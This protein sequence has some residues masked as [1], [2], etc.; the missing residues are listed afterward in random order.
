VGVGPDSVAADED[1]GEREGD[2]RP[3]PHGRLHGAGLGAASV[4]AVVVAVACGI[5]W[6]Y[7]LRAAGLLAYG[8]EVPGAPPLQQLA[9]SDAQPLVRLVLSWIPAGA[10]AGLARSVAQGR[11]S[12]PAAC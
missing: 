11:P 6:T 4:A 9:G 3:S 5:G 12:C 1:P 10:A 2:Q 8:P 7:V